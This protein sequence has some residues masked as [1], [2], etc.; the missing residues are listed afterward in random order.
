MF[1]LS[2]VVNGKYLKH[3]VKRLSLY[4]SRIKF[5]PLVW[6]NTH[7]YILVDRIEDV[8][9]VSKLTDDRSCDRDITLFG[10]VRG[11]HLHPSTRVHLIG[12]GDFDISTM[13]LL[14]DPCAASNDTDKSK[15]NIRSTLKVKDN[16]LY[17]PMT[18]IGRV[19]VDKDG[20]YI[21]IHKINY[22]KAEHLQLADQSLPTHQMPLSSS[23]DSTPMDLLRSMQDSTKNVVEPIDY[24]E[25]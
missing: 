22:T 11:T 24:T 7:P 3:E 4:I 16:L 13:S 9:A 14:D 15:K 2:G 1:D 19:I 18:N 5:R 10:Y 23:T 21:D 12:A 20:L 25:G 6:R 17:A 8:T